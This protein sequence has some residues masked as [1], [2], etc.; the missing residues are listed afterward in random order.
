[1]YRKLVPYDEWHF[2]EVDPVRLRRCS[3]AFQ[4]Q[5][6][7][8]VNEHKDRYAF[9]N[10]TMPILHAA[11]RGDIRNTL[12]P[13]VNPFISRDYYHDKGEGNLPAEYDTQFTDAE[14]AFS[15]ALQGLSLE[16]TPKTIKD[17]ITYGLVDI[18]EEGDWPDKVKYR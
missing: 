5:I 16:P 9:Y 18:E 17:G 10:K 3:L 12:D 2:T 6:N 4:H 7:T 11:I 15:V 14:A 8:K 13:D 1:M